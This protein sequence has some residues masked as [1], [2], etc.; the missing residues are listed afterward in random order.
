M[1]SES[2]DLALR[3]ALALGL[4][5]MTV[6]V[7]L[8]LQVLFMRLHAQRRER[9]RAA[10]ARQWQPLMAQ[11]ALGEVLVEPLPAVRRHERADLMML[12]L[13]LQDGLRGSAHDGLNR[14]AERVG[15]SQDARRWAQP[16]GA[17]MARRVLGLVALGHFG[18][19]EDEPLLRQALGDALPLVSLGAARALLQIDAAAAAPAVLDEYLRRADWPIARVGTLL[20]EAGADAVAPP[21][22]QRLLDGSVA[23]Q[24]S[25]LPLLRF[26]ETPHGG[27]VLNR[28]VERS[29]DPQVLSIALRQLHGPDA[30]PRVRALADHPDALVRSAAAQALGRIGDE[31][32][33]ERL[34]ALMSDRDWWVR[35]RAAQAQ[36]AL[37]RTDAEAIVSLRRRLA[38][39]F[40]RDALDHVCAEQSMRREGMLPLPAAGGAA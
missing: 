30:L 16:A 40:A 11:A 3:L 9:E 13:R 28:L 38:D 34:L 21:L 39:R 7:G 36:L 29:E 22:I 15:L 12:W 1:F 23:Q 27:G 32:D 24:Q 14:L 26:A 25:L 19:R 37:P 10:L 6:A 33:R 4:V 31:S 20:R 8:T 18:H 17:S 5:S 2:S 35:Y